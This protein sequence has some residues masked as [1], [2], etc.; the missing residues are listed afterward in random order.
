M[1]RLVRLRPH[2]QCARDMRRR[3]ET[4]SVRLHDPRVSTGAMRNNVRWLQPGRAHLLL[5][6]AYDLRGRGR[7]QPVWLYTL[8]HRQELRSGRMRRLVRDLRCT[9]DLQRRTY[10]KRLR[11]HTVLFGQDLRFRWLPRFVR[12]LRRADDVRGRRDARSMWRHS[13][14][15][16][17]RTSRP[18]H[19]A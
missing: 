16:C 4:K 14:H 11:L 12:D 3:R 7:A 2:V 9:H 19:R 5:H 8:V 1:R 13:R 17:N 6:R 18:R 10:A 15:A